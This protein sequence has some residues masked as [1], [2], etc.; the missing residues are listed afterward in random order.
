[1]EKSNLIMNTLYIRRSFRLLK[2]PKKSSDLGSIFLRRSIRTKSL[3][4]SKCYS[5]VSKTVN[6]IKIESELKFFAESFDVEYSRRLAKK[7]IARYNPI[8][9]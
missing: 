5:K 8:S 6:R 1:M 2:L 9:S 7:A 3:K 4:L